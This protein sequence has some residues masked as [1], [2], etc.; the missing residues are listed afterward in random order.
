MGKT[1][2]GMCVFVIKES[3]SS[4]TELKGLP[5]IVGINVLSDLKNLFM[6]TE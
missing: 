3:E 4:V 5:G 2:H 6:V 1:L